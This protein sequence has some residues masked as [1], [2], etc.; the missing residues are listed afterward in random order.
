MK[1]GPQGMPSKPTC[2]ADGAAGGALLPKLEKHNLALLAYQLTGD[3]LRLWS[4]Y[5]RN[6]HAFEEQLNEAL[7][8]LPLFPITFYAEGHRGRRL[9]VSS[10]L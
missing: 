3:G 1:R 9:Q 7:K 8:E 5:T 4:L 6:I 2:R 10:L